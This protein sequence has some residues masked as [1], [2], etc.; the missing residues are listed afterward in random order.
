MVGI[1]RTV[2]STLTVILRRLVAL[3]VG[4]V[5]LGREHQ[6]CLPAADG[7]QSDITCQSGAFG[8]VFASLL[9]QDAYWVIIVVDTKVLVPVAIL[10]ID[11]LGWIAHQ[12]LAIHL[13]TGSIHRTILVPALQ[14]VELHLQHIV[15]HPVAQ[16]AIEAHLL[17]IGI[18]EHTLLVAI[19]KIGIVRGTLVTTADIDVMVMGKGCARYSI[20][21][22]GVVAAIGIVSLSSTDIRTIHHVEFLSECS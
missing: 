10:G 20:E 6:I 15:E 12:G 3:V 5:T 8:L 16:S 11:G 4:I 14:D 19:G 21:P 2:L 22:V 7:L 18:D 13:L 17:A 1:T 9:V